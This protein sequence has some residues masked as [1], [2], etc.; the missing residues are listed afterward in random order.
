MRSK[1]SF[2]LP[3]VLRNKR[4]E[5][6]LQGIDGGL[7]ELQEVLQKYVDFLEPEKAPEDWVYWLFYALGGEQYYRDDFDDVE[8][9]KVLRSLFRLYTLK[10]TSKGVEEHLRALARAE[11]VYI[12]NPKDASFLSPALTQEEREKFEAKFR[13][14][15]ILPYCRGGKRY[16]YTPFVDDFCFGFP[17]TASAHTRLYGA[18]FLYDPLT[19][20]EERITVAPLPFDTIEIPKPG[21]A[22]G[23]FLG[24]FCRFLYRHGAEERLFRVVLSGAARDAFEYRTS[25]ALIPSLYP[26][27]IRYRERYISGWAWGIFPS[28]GNFRHF[29][30]ESSACYRIV[31]YFKVFEKERATF[32]ERTAM[33][34]LGA[35]RLG[36]L[37]PFTCE[38]GADLARKA[39]SFESLL[40]LCVYKRFLTQSDALARIERA[41][42]A[43]NLARAAG[44]KVI[45]DTAPRPTLKSSEAV[46]CGRYKCGGVR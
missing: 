26:T 37:G 8:K 7:F 2:L 1:L 5:G 18:V 36:P 4:F 32:G 23:A 9:R 25:K 31:R 19:G 3:N 38:V 24:R 6:F 35:R 30:V 17:A 15:R 39:T 21:R 40:P 34:F 14:V 33:F 22:I 10:G 27:L 28:R 45:L 12:N 29:T 42:W 13:E 44:I 41:R 16:L 20:N 11:V 46:V 43:I